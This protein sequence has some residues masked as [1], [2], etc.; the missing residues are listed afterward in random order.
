MLHTTMIAGLSLFVFCFSSFQPVSQ[1]GL[2]LFTLLLTAL[3]GD[4]VLLPAL[5]ATPLGRFFGR[6]TNLER[7]A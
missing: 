2:L 5:L 6:T 7:Q 4:L 1:F 3:V